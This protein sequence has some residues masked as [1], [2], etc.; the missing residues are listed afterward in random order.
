[1]ASHEYQCFYMLHPITA[2][3]LSLIFLLKQWLHLD[4][5]HVYAV[6]M[7]GKTM[8]WGFTCL[9]TPQR[10]PGRGSIIAGNFLLLPV[11]I[12]CKIV[13]KYYYIMF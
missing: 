2:L 10:G 12:I 7:V 5:H 8:M 11:V 3:P 9:I 6:T 13:F 1:M 4:Y